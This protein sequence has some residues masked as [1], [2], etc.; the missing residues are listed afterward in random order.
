VRARGCHSGEVGNRAARAGAAVR[1]SFGS[2]IL[3]PLEGD[4]V[5]GYHHRGHGRHGQRQV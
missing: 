1:F 3:S 2:G 5:R 4:W